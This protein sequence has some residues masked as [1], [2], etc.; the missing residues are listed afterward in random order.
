ML[1]GPYPVVCRLVVYYRYIFTLFELH[2]S[3]RYRIR[4]FITTRLV[5]TD[6]Y[7]T[8][9]ML[10]MYI[11]P[12]NTTELVYTKGVLTMLVYIRLVGGFHSEW[13]YLLCGPL[14]E[15]GADIGVERK[16]CT[17]AHVRGTA[18]TDDQ[19]GGLRDVQ[20]WH[21]FRHSVNE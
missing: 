16:P 7:N 9:V 10:Y 3:C 6:A 1:S 21:L 11:R 12:V 5:R 8:L 14:T 13:H 20:L 4:G 2:F 18:C 15:A 17:Q 19:H